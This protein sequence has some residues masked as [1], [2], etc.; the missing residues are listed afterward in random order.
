VANVFLDCAIGNVTVMPWKCLGS[1]SRAPYI[2]NLG[3]R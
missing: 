3:T 2:F 1:G